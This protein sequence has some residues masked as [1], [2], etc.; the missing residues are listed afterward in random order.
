MALMMAT[1]PEKTLAQPV[2]TPAMMNR[3]KKP[4]VARPLKATAKI[5]LRYLPQNPDCM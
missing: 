5:L 4:K 2:T 3:A 1:G